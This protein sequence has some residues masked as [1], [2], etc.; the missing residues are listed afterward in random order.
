MKV[1]ELVDEKPYEITVDVHG[2]REGP[3]LGRLR[4]LNKVFYSFPSL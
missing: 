4:F 2:I 1:M 3:R